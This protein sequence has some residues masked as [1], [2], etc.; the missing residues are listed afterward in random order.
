V[1]VRD[2]G[3]WAKEI[4]ERLLARDLT[5]PAELAERIFPTLVEALQRANPRVSDPALIHDAAGDAFLAYIKAPA[6][7]D[8]ARRSLLGYL[9]MAAQGDLVNALARER[10][11]RRREQAVDDVELVTAL[12]KESHGVQS[13]AFDSG[14]PDGASIASKVQARVCE[15]FPDARDREIAELVIAGER[16]SARFA[17]VLSIEHLPAGE[18]RRVVKLHKDRIKKRIHRLGEGKQ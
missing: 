10:R 12:G 7:F 5:A 17:S 1:N 18:L 16:S 2:S 11:R 3:N 6:M 14:S 4:H 9:K 8:P 15:L 13:H